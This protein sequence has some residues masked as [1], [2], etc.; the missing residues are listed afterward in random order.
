[1]AYHGKPIRD[2]QHPDWRPEPA[3]LEWHGREVFKGEARFRGGR[4]G[5]DLG[6]SSRSYPAGEVGRSDPPSGPVTWL[7]RTW[8]ASVLDGVPR[9]DPDG[10]PCTR[11]HRRRMV[12]MPGEDDRGPLPPGLYEEVVDR[13]VDRRIGELAGRG[14]YADVEPLDEGDSHAVLAD[15]IRRLAR[16]ALDGLTGDDRV[17]R[18]ARL[19]DRADPAPVRG[20]E[21][22]ERLLVHPARRLLGVWPGGPDGPRRPERPDTPLALG[23]LLAGTRLDPSLVSQ[24]RKE[25][26]S[27]DRVDILC[28]FIKWSGIRILEDDLRAFAARPGGPAPR[29]D[30]QLPGR[31]RPQGGRPAAVAAEHRGPR[32]VRHPPHPAARQGLPVPPRHRLRHGLRRLGQPVAAGLDRGAGVDGQGQPVRVA[33][34]LGPRR[35]DVRDLLGGRRVRRRTTPSER[36]R[37]QA[38][39]EQERGAATRP[40][41]R[42]S[43]SSCGPTPSSRRSSTGSTPSGASR[44]ATAT[45]WSPRPAP[46][47]R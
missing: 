3:H 46:A 8:I 41:A 10:A 12:L 44:A 18:Q 22:E 25:L 11:T 43:C 29:A 2:P 15:H 31:D 27:A 16:E 21:T 33:A 35:R 38:A 17:G 40:T 9:G 37:L 5:P 47:R 14:C 42:P 26:A 1:M 45:S 19:C 20:A 30:D 32:L 23:C 13:G 4:A 24:L 7:D 34:P 28:S 36:P 39:L 6:H